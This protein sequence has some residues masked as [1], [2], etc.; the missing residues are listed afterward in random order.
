MRYSKLQT[1]KTKSG[2]EYKSIFDIS[3]NVD[4]FEHR[5]IR[6]S[7]QRLD[8]LADKYY[9]DGRYWWVIALFNKVTNPLKIELEYLLIPTNL[10]DIIEY[11]RQE[12]L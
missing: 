8:A 11:V 5:K 12:S 4:N 3:I 7:N 9:N 10:N 2:K 6:Y 1:L